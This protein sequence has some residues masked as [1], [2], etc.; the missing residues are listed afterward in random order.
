MSTPR[1]ATRMER[2]VPFYVMDL[3]AR[4][5]QLEA[6]GR[7]V[8]HMEVGEP[9]FVTP[10]PILREGIAS[11][12]RGETRYTSNSGTIELRTALSHHLFVGL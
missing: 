8:I 1:I 6:Q 3:L 10:E 9:D 12:K 2:I 4:A 11:L 7:S 5:K